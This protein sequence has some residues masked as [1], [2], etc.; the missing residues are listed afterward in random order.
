MMRVV[1]DTNVVVSAYLS[2]GG[3]LAAVLDL[4]ANRAIRMFVSRAILAEYES[5]L[6]RPRLNLEP[7][8]VKEA[9]AELRRISE[10]VEPMMV[11]SAAG[12]EPDNRFLECAQ[13]AQ[14]DFLITGNARHYPAAYGRT[15][16]VTPREFLEAAGGYLLQAGP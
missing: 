2:H 6:S 5:V 9:L 7:V 15:R 1:V 14:A 13:A 8:I 4:A 12:H 10:V 3:Y 11:A 16:V